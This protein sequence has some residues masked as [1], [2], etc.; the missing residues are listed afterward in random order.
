MRF[1]KFIVATVVSVFSFPSAANQCASKSTN[2]C[3]PLLVSQGTGCAWMCGFC[4][5]SLGT[6][7]FYFTGNPPVCTYQSGQGCV[8]NPQAGV[9]Y[10][11][12]A[13]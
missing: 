8:G 1:F 2:N 11:C 12:C 9:E 13:L 5:S 3:V 4:A 6:D 10:T 7:N